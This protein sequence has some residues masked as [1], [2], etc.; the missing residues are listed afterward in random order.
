MLF[1][2][3]PQLTTFLSP[4]KCLPTRYMNQDT[5][6][7]RAAISPVT[8]NTDRATL[9]FLNSFDEEA[10]NEGTDWHREGC[11]TQIFGNHLQIDG[12]VQV[13]SDVYRTRLMLQGD[14]WVG[15]CS[16]ENDFSGA[17]YATMLERLERGTELPESPNEVGE[18]SIQELIEDALDRHL[19]DTEEEYLA[20]LEKRYRRYEMEGEIYDHDLVR[21]N[22]KWDVE[23]FEPLDL[24]PVKPADIL[25][26][27]NYIAYIFEK[28]NQRY[29]KFM[30]TV[31]DL[32]ATHER[33]R[34]WEWEKEIQ[35]WRDRVSDVVRQPPPLSSETIDLRFMITTTEAKLQVCRQEDTLEKSEEN[36]TDEDEAPAE[37]KFETVND[38]DDVHA[39]VAK[40]YQGALRFS[41]VANIL[42]AHYLQH[43]ETVGAPEIRLDQRRG[44]ELLNHLFHQAALRDSLITLDENPFL[45]FEEP[46]KWVCEDDPMVE[47]C[48]ALRLMSAQNEPIPYALRVLPGAEMLYLS[49]EAVFFGPDGWDEAEI[50]PE[51]HIPKEAAAT[52]SGVEFLAKIGAPL[53]DSLVG[54]VED[55]S[56]EVSISVEIRGKADSDNELIHLRVVAEDP[57][58]LRR[59]ELRKDEWKIVHQPNANGEKLMRFNR[60][61]LY[62]FPF[63]I[64]PIVSSWDATEEAFRVRLTRNFPERFQA[65]AKALPKEIKL[66]L[67]DSLGSI[68]ERPVEASV[69]FE[70]Q[71]RDMD[72]FDLRIRVDAEGLELSDKEI[73]TLV[74]ARGEFVRM[75]NG[76][77]LRLDFNLDEQQRK[78]IDRLGLDPFDLSGET[79]RMHVLQLADPAS[80]EV[81]DA[82][83]WER[84]NERSSSLKLQVTPKLP[85]EL[86][87]VN[88]RPYQV[89]GFQFLAYLSTNRFGG[90]LADDMGLGKTLQ[91]LTWLLWLRTRHDDDNVPPSLVVC[92]K[93]VLDV[94]AGEVKKFAPTLNIQVLRSKEEMDLEALESKL[95]IL[96]LNYAQLRV[97]IEQLKAIKWLA[98]V[99]DEG[100]QIK[101]PDSKA[102]KSSRMLE[103]SNRLVLTGTPLE[104]R[105]LDIWS[106]MS[107]AMPGVLGDRKYFREHFDRRKD[108]KAQSRLAARLR[109]FMLRRTKDQVA[110]DLPPRIEED[111]LCKME[112]DQ[113]NLYE[114]ELNRIQSIL[115][116]AETDDQLRKNSFVIL[117]GLMRLRQIC[118][119]PGLLDPDYLEAPSA[120]LIALFYLLDQLQEEGHKVLVFSQFTSMLEIIRKKL[121]DENRPHC[122]LTGQTKD[123][124]S[125]VEG[126]QRSKDPTCFLLS[127]KAGGSG[128]NL[129]A[130][131]YVVLYDPWW[132]PAVENQAIDRTHRIGQTNKVI[133][134]RLLMRDS[135]EEK[136][137]VLQKQKAEMVTGILGEESFTRNLRRQDLAFLF[138]EAQE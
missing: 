62:R 67:D 117:Q 52:A 77:W 69:K 19:E 123:R 56:L 131:S 119:H 106:L 21:L 1:Q 14:R 41:A 104:N 81:F 58:A 16:S 30:D 38:K 79:H 46:M 64:E 83:T 105:L 17:V 29:P 132:N 100:Q 3:N 76:K 135:V 6:R 98:V 114:D 55:R 10:R 31:T 94:W 85:P 129:T 95:D 75:K 99:L 71:E 133:A 13:D 90:I 91:G 118:C 116:G 33:M 45:L 88:L 108:V 51:Y 93:S 128:L 43:W 113:A 103:A 24:W 89:D 138:G 96:V 40:Y 20:K 47:N 112:E 97:C 48:F 35:S 121:D 42:W 80:K 107:F 7:T 22:P 53:P 60:R 122:L 61:I 86:N 137:R 72:W 74:E 110:V 120:K 34:T 25:E 92:P 130:S 136:I 66:N 109:P 57:E 15:E 28:K 27:W 87:N 73:R 101:N 84:I 54:Q 12:R 44:A 4:A 68:M 82:A 8:M 9:D 63:L 23:S 5:R 111:V 37:P 49:D 36:K 32:N 65:W 70:I 2:G 115:A 39:L 102:A 26:F 18:K 50:Q 78:A 126:F 134:Y 127:L 59:E 124:Q 125:V 11:V